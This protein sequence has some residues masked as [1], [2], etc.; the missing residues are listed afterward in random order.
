MAA[1]LRG[2]A[3][4]H[5]ANCL[6][7]DHRNQMSPLPCVGRTVSAASAQ[8]SLGPQKLLD[9]CEPLENCGTCRS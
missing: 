7:E 2:Q 8:C 5:A 4:P 6:A 1:R 3:Q 9:A